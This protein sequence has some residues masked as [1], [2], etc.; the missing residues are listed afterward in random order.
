MIVFVF[1]KYFLI[2]DIKLSFYFD[3]HTGSIKSMCLI[4]PRKSFGLIA[5]VLISGFVEVGSLR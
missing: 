3:L 4:P 2:M 5:R 1:Q